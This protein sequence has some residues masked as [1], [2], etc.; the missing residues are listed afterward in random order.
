MDKNLK[1]I[2]KSKNKIAYTVIEFL[3]KRQLRSEIHSLI[4]LA[5]LTHVTVLRLI[6]SN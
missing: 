5:D 4:M 6:H 3:S 1:K 2:L